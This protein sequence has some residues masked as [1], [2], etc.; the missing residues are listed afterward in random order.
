MKFIILFFTLMGFLN[1]SDACDAHE[2][3]YH[4]MQHGFVLAVDDKFAS[5]LVANGHHSRQAEITGT[6]TIENAEENE[7]R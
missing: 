4:E 6:L 1:Q 2:R 7:T 5:H 3:T